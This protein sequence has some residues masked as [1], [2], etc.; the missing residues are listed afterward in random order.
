M[1]EG[2]TSASRN[3]SAVIHAR[4]NSDQMFSLPTDARKCWVR[5]SPVGEG[6]ICCGAG[7]A[8]ST[9]RQT[10]P[11]SQRAAVQKEWAALACEIPLW[12]WGNWDR[13]LLALLLS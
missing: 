1:H 4:V 5:R 8:L 7:S 3:W 11:N 10:V 9:C 13:L 2:M 12:A 6:C